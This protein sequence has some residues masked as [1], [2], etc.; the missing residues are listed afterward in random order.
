MIAHQL[1]RAGCRRIREAS[2]A[3]EVDY[4]IKPVDRMELIARVRS[5]FTGRRPGDETG[6]C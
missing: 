2:S 6:R 4:I 3:G 1:R 5:S